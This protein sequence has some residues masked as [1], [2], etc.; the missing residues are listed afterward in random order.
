MRGWRPKGER[1]EGD[2]YC[3]G[4]CGAGRE[5]DK[6]KWVHVYALGVVSQKAKG[7]RGRKEMKQAIPH[8]WAAPGDPER[9]RVRTRTA[10][11]ELL[12][13]V[14]RGLL[15]V[16]QAAVP[17]QWDI[18]RCDMPCYTAGMQEGKRRGLDAECIEDEQGGSDE[19]T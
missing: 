4:R 18:Y 3:R 15:T 8:P 13:D 5:G 9:G 6:G 12:D 7:G 14:P 16:V 19:V 2:G 10:V 1:A 17:L 11:E